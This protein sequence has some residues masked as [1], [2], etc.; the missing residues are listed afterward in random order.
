MNIS[1]IAKIIPSAFFFAGLAIL[2]AACN[3]NQGM[4]HGGSNMSTG[5][6]NWNWVQIIVCLGVGFVLG[7]LFNAVVSKRRR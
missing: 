7:Y 1:R 3:D 4:M 5:L 6:A 2:M